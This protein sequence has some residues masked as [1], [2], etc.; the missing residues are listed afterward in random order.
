MIATGHTLVF[1]RIRAGRSGEGMTL[2]SLFIWALSIK[3]EYRS[4]TLHFILFFLSICQSKTNIVHLDLF[5]SLSSH[6]SKCNQP[7]TTL[8][9]EARVIALIAAR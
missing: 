4:S 7:L 1:Q 9:C 6:M 5:L 8:T 2:C 3:V